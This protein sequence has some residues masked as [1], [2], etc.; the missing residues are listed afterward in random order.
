MPFPVLS[1]LTL[2]VCPLPYGGRG[3][4][5]YLGSFHRL[6]LYVDVVKVF[7]YFGNILVTQ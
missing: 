5:L 2:F 6:V 1:L 3:A 4:L 7:C